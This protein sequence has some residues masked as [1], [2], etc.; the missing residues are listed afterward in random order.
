VIDLTESP[1]AADGPYVDFARSGKGTLPWQQPAASDESDSVAPAL[2]TVET[3][4]SS[5]NLDV[6][7]AVALVNVPPVGGF[8]PPGVLHPGT[9]A[10]SQPQP[11]D[12]DERQ[13]DG[14]DSKPPSGNGERQSNPILRNAGLYVV[15][16]IFLFAVGLAIRFHK[17]I[18]M[19]L[20]TLA[21]SSHAGRVDQSYDG[22]RSPEQASIPDVAGDLEQQKQDKIT[23]EAVSEAERAAEQM[24]A[25]QE[26]EDAA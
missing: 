14:H 12:F 21:F 15:A 7:E 19:T 23:A 24:A 5:Q 11:E 16:C 20:S 25:D 9:G 26:K 22:G 4:G 10:T 17:E 13:S 1:S 2:P 3:D 6:S 8:A 18:T